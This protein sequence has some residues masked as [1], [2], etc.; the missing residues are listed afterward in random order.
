MYSVTYK[1]THKEHKRFR[2]SAGVK[3][4]HCEKIS[5]KRRTA[6][7][8][9]TEEDRQKDRQKVEIKLCL[10]TCVSK[11]VL[12]KLLKAVDSSCVSVPVYCNKCLHTGED[13]I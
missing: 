3:E 7:E 4:R 2:S 11:P 9:T 13:K 8:V 12:L 6:E 10:L 5:N 1:T